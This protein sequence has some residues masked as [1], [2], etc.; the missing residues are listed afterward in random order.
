METNVLI[1]NNA[2]LPNVTGQSIVCTSNSVVGSGAFYY[3]GTNSIGCDWGNNRNAIVTFDAARGE[4]KTDGTIKS[5]SDYKVF[6]KSDTVMVQHVS[7]RYWRRT[8]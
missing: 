2:G 7:S 6:G 4:T 3:E 5:V 1:G 8:S